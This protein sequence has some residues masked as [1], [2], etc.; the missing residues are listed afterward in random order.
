MGAS[1]DDFGSDIAV[2]SSGNAYSGY[3]KGN[4]F[5]PTPVLENAFIAK[6]DPTGNRLWAHQFGPGN[7]D[8][9]A[10]TTDATGSVY[11]AGQTHGDFGQ[12]NAGHYDN[13]VIKYDTNGSVVWTKQWG[14]PTW[15]VINALAIDPSGNVLVSGQTLG[16]LAGNNAGKKNTHSSVS[17][18]RPVPYYGRSSLA[19]L[20]KMYR[21]A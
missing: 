6:Y 1:K 20:V 12:A 21:K 11:V 19:L 17:S 5:G 18:M 3:T 14:S 7:E 13:F 16:S 10:V 9:R 2:D 8:G 4:L 15:D